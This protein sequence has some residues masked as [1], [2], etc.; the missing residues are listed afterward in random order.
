MADSKGM[1]AGVKIG[2]K[3]AEVAGQV[4]SPRP[5]C[6]PHVKTR[7]TGAATKGLMHLKSD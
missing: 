2:T 1:K 3:L 4:A 5:P 7:G 6:E